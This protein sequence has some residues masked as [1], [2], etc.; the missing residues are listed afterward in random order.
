M[1][2]GLV[3]TISNTVGITVIVSEKVVEVAIV[4]VECED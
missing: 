1:F 4:I 2:M 3:R